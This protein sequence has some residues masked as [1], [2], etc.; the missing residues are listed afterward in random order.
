MPLALFISVHVDSPVAL[1]EAFD[2][3]K[4]RFFQLTPVVAC[5]PSRFSI[6]V[7][8][9]LSASRSVKLILSKLAI[10]P[11]VICPRTFSVLSVTSASLPP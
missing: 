8:P 4:E 11:A 7:L 2:V 6:A 3:S 9:A 1:A 10:L 5:P